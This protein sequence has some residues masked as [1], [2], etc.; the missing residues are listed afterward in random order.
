LPEP[1]AAFC[2]RP[3]HARFLPIEPWRERSPL[4]DGYWKGLG[5]DHRRAPEQ[6]TFRLTVGQRDV[7][8]TQCMNPPLAFFGHAA[9]V[10]RWPLLGVEPTEVS[11]ARR[12]PFDPERTFG[13]HTPLLSGKVLELLFAVACFGRYPERH[14]SLGITSSR[15]D[16]CSARCGVALPIQRIR[17]RP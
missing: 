5:C 17:R 14:E 10:F 11:R 4:F 7:G 16:P 8:L 15:R 2:W 6:V 12:S 13:G 1:E 3:L 9:T